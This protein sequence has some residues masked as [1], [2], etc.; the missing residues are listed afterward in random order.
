MAGLG[1]LL[2]NEGRVHTTFHPR[3][4]SA[5]DTSWANKRACR[6]VGGWSVATNIEIFSDHWPIIIGLAGDVGPVRRSG[7]AG[8]RLPRWSVAQLDLGGL[9]AGALA[10]S[11]AP[12]SNSAS[13]EQFAARMGNIL[14]DICDGAMPR[15]PMS[16][17]L[18]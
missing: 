3:G 1:F 14:S 2:P 13:A 16:G 10:A 4:T 7:R 11:W 6:L 17:G 5:V 18:R 12:L 9:E 15:A 8:A